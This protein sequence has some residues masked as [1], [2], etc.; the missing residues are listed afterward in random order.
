MHIPFAFRLSPSH[1]FF[2]F[3]FTAS[4]LIIFCGASLV[5][6]AAAAVLGPCWRACGVGG[7]STTA[8]GGA[9]LFVS[10]QELSDEVWTVQVLLRLPCV[11]LPI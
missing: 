10:L 2:P 5:V 11:V 7:F 4:F 6:A 1:L 9:S 3:G 8:R